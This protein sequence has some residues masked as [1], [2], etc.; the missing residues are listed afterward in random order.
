MF[1]LLSTQGIKKTF[2]GVK[3]L[4]DVS[5]AIEKGQ[6]HSI[7]G[8]NG[9]GKSTLMNI[10]MGIHHPDKGKILYN[11]KEIIINSPIDAQKVGIGI[12]PQEL[13]LVPHL[14]VSENINL[15]L[16]PTKGKVFTLVDKKKQDIIAKNAI[17]QLNPDIY[18]NAMADSLSV[19]NQQLVQIA[20][21]LAFGAQII[22]FDE[23]TASL[24]G[25][26]TDNLLEIIKKLK[27]NNV[28][29]FYISHRLEEVMLISDKISVM[30]DGSL[31]SSFKP[32]Q[33]NINGLVDEMVGRKITKTENNRN[34]DVKENPVVLEVKD[35][36]RKNEFKDINFTLHEGEILGISG[37]VGSG[38][39]ELALSIFGK[40]KPDKGEI[41]VN[42]KKVVIN[43]PRNALDL[44]VAYVPEERRVLGIIPLL[45]VE[46]NMSLS[47][48]S[49]Y[50]KKGRINDNLIKSDVLKYIES[51]GI[52]VSSTKQRIK[53]L[54]GGNQQKVIIARCLLSNCKIL[55]LD[56]PTRGI[57]VNGK[58]E[59][60]DLL[61]F[62]TTKGYSIIVISSEMEE[63]LDL[64]DRILIM[65]EGI[66]KGEVLS[67][68]ATQ[69]KIM[70]IALTN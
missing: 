42:G 9:A 39:T 25:K 32:S 7:V 21:V 29:I 51:L 3:A 52:K 2:P 11:G 49:Y 31:V 60:H 38:R 61:R 57:D 44:G 13:N 24:T 64:S 48:L 41:S 28:A 53:N 43:H 4:D 65:H 58:Q 55:I 22:I 26:E 5:I 10:F 18:I 62:L 59:I 1:P 45:S 12:V 36:S 50:F 33:I 37:L 40:T 15:G 56:E 23:P 34:Y 17:N 16:L 63:V 35:F 6:I 66:K 69:E 67:K 20:R 54:S 8:E 70:Q 19:A 27:S 68:Q 47:R 46:K 14:S 30:R